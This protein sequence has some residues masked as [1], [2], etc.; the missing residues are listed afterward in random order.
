MSDNRG[1]QLLRDWANR[2][3]V[4]VARQVKMRKHRLPYNLRPYDHDVEEVFQTIMSEEVDAIELT[5]SVDEITRLLKD[6]EKLR[7]L[8]YLPEVRQAMFYYRLSGELDE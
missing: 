5:V 1:Y 3:G 6:Q 2:S 7:Q 8:M 4:S